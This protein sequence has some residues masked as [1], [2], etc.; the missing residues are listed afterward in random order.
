MK[1]DLEDRNVTTR[2]NEVRKETIAAVESID[3]SYQ[4]LAKLLHETYDN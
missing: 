2:S 1:S 4:A 3:E